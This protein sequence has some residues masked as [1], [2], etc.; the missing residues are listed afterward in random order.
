M[1]IYS[2]TPFTVSEQRRPWTPQTP[3]ALNQH[4]SRTL[5]FN[6][7]LPVP[8]IV[9]P[10]TETKSIAVSFKILF[11][12]TSPLLDRKIHLLSLLS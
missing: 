5:T 4:G 12:L 8:D 7:N 6:G 11:V 9:G 2:P 1:I 3:Q 10:H